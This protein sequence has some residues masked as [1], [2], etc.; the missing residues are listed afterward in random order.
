MI[1][2]EAFLRKIGVAPRKIEAPIE[3]K[4]GKKTEEVKAEVK[5]DTKKADKKKKKK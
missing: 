5:K 4:E 3:E 1:D 2:R